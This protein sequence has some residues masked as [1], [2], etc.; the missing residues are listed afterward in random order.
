MP[1]RD[2]MAHIKNKCELKKGKSYRYDDEFEG[3][4]LVDKVRILDKIGLKDRKIPVYSPKLRANIMI[5]KN[6]IKC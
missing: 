6:R 3:F 2:K 1:V 4:R 5:F